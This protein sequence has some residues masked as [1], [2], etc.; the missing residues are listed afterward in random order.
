[1]TTRSDGYQVDAWT[2]SPR[3][4][5]RVGC[6]ADVTHAW[7]P[8][9]VYEIGAGTGDVTSRFI[10][11]GFVVTAYDLGTESR[12]VLRSRFG[13][14][15]RVID[16]PARL[17]DETFDYVFAFEVLEH[18]VDDRAALG[19]W[20]ERLRP[21]GRLLVSV[22]AHQH[23][24]SD[25]DRAVGHVRRYERS[26]LE[27]L[28][29]GVGLEQIELANYGFP[30]GNAL[31]WTQ[32]GLRQITGNRAERPDDEQERIDRTVRSGVQTASPLNKLRRLSSPP[33]MQPFARLQ[34]IAYRRDWSDGYVVTAVRPT[35]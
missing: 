30:M 13:D 26:E 34:R 21:G 14:R 27:A 10:D 25:A 5:L 3:H 1:M 19:E 9:S 23:K 6:I 18:I 11:R 31:R 33:A 32:N 17:G 29:T 24:Y 2:P 7:S 16:S 12:A 35:A 8:G 22:P 15:I 28:L 4:L 20:I